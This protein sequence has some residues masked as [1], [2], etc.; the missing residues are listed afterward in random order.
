[1][2]AITDLRCGVF[3]FLVQDISEQDRGPLFHEAPGDD[4]TCAAGRSGDD[5]DSSFEIRHAI[6]FLRGLVLFSPGAGSRT[7]P[8]NTSRIE[9]RR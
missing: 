9:Y 7:G 4:R 5:G 1:M 6:F 2:G 3:C 8:A